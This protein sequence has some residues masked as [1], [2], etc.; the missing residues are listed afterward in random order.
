MTSSGSGWP[1]RF[2]RDED[3]SIIGK[4]SDGI[5]F[6]SARHPI[7]MYMKDE[8]IEEEETGEVV[9]DSEYWR[10]RKKRR[11]FYRKKSQIILEDSSFRGP[12]NA[13]SGLQ[14]EGKV[15]NVSMADAA[16]A[17]S[18]T[19]ITAKIKALASTKAPFKYVLLQVVKKD[20]IDDITKALSSTTEVNVIPV[21]EWYQF[22]KPGVAGQ[23]FLDEIDD[24]FELQQ[25]Q[26]KEKLE[27][28]KRIT[29]AMKLD[30]NRSESN[31]KNSNNDEGEDGKRFNLPAIFG[32]AA[33]K[34][35]KAGKLFKKEKVEKH[36]DENGM[37]LD[38]ARSFHDYCKG[39]YAA[40]RADDED[41]VGGEQMDLDEKEDILAGQAVY[42]HS[43]ENEGDSEDEEEEEEGE[44]EEESGGAGGARS[45]L[46]DESVEI[47]AKEFKRQMA[48]KDKVKDEQTQKEREKGSQG[49]K[50]DYDED[51]DGGIRKKSRTE[52]E[53]PASSSSQ[54]TAAPTAPA[55]SGDST[56]DYEMTD[57]GVRKYIT[58]AGGMVKI[59]DL[60]EV[61]PINSHQS[62][63][64]YWT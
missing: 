20:A 23:K 58:N 48:S 53:S 59:A 30:Q 26:D 17:G 54:Q 18:S 50:R 38:E 62:A 27:K 39:D 3:E 36:L 4:F 56:D 49:G 29:H 63:Y 42:E 45:G 1:L 11:S 10:N 25:R 13:V 37:D 44:E 5:D 9:K 14:Y 2:R 24:D 19:M 43:D 33:G 22:K 31:G 64:Y 8:E 7:K 40:E 28:Y 41:D 6:D 16:E 32:S 12:N 35:V 57:D 55:P 52:A 46:V 21:A 51:S 47:S 61:R 34:S 60:K 15:S